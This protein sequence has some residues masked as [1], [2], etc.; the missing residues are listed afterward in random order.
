MCQ[1]RESTAAYD[2]ERVM[3][4]VV[5]ALNPTPLVKIGITSNI[6]RRIAALRSG[7]LHIRLAAI[8]PKLFV[9]DSMFFEREAH[10]ALADKKVAPG[11]R[12]EWFGCAVADAVAVLRGMDLTV[13]TSA[14]EW[15]LHPTMDGDRTELFRYTRAAPC[16]LS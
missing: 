13:Y 12:H 6:C 8:A 4:Y 10:R 16:P 5:E 2:G 7:P 3:I 11:T 9:E 14:D 15:G 1:G